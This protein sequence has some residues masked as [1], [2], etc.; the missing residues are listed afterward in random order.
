VPAHS[1]E[2]QYVD[3][4]GGR[5]ERLSEKGRFLQGFP[6][7]H[8]LYGLAPSQ[9]GTVYEQ[10]GRLMI[11]SNAR[12]GEYG[13]ALG[14]AQ[15]YPPKYGHWVNLPDEHSILVRSRPLPTN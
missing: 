6:V 9:P 8:C 11:P 1:G 10:Q 15:S 13:V 12:A 14:F 2:S 3:R 5:W 4:D 7:L